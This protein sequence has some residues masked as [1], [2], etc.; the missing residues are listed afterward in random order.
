MTG[1]GKWILALILA[2]M[3]ALTAGLRGANVDF[4]VR[5]TRFWFTDDY[6]AYDP[7]GSE[8]HTAK[9]WA[10]DNSNF[11]L[12]GGTA[13]A[14]DGNDSFEYDVADYS[15][16]SKS[17][18]TATTVT[19]R[20]EA[21]EDDTGSRTTY[22]TST[23]DDDDAH[24]GPADVA[25]IS[26][27]NQG[28]NAWTEYGFYGSQSQKVK[29]AIFWNYSTPAA[30]TALDAV[31]VT[32]SGF[33]ARWSSSANADAYRLDVSTDA[34]F[35]SYVAGYQNRL[36]SGTE[37]TVSLA[38][39]TTYFYRVRA[40][41]GDKTSGSSNTV[42]TV[43]VPAAPVLTASDGGQTGKVVLTWTAVAGADGGYDVFRHTVNDAGGATQ[44]NGSAV[45]TNATEDVSVN[46]GPPLFGVTYYY[47]V[48]A[49]N[50]VS[51][52]GALSAA[53]SGFHGL[54][55][56]PGLTA[57]RGTDPDKVQLAWAVVPVADGYKV[58]RNSMD[59]P[60][61]ATVI[62]TLAGLGSTSFADTTAAADAIYYY[63]VVSTL[64]GET[65]RFSTAAIGQ[66]SL[67]VPGN[68]TATIGV[69]NDRIRVSWAAAPPSTSYQIFRSTTPTP[70]GSPYATSTGTSFD[71]TGV[72][73]GTTYY[74]WVRGTDGSRFSALS[75]ATLGALGAG[76]S[77][78]LGVSAAGSVKLTGS[79]SYA[80]EGTPYLGYKDNTWPSDDDQWRAYFWWTHA[81]LPAGIAIDQAVLASLGLVKRDYEDDDWFSPRGARLG[82][83]RAS[84]DGAG[85]STRYGWMNI[86]GVS[87]RY[88]EVGS[89][90]GNSY[91]R[92]SIVLERSHL[93]AVRDGNFG[94]GFNFTDHSG[95]SGDDST[96]SEVS[97]G[98]ITVSYFTRPTL[99]SPATGTQMS[100]AS[101]FNLAWNPALTTFDRLNY[102]VQVA[103]NGSFSP[104]LVDTL[105]TAT[106]QAVS[107]A[108][109]GTYSWRV[110]IE[111]PAQ[112]ENA[113]AWSD[114]WTVV[115][116]PPPIPAAPSYLTARDGISTAFVR[117]TW[118][119]VALAS[120]YRVFRGTSNDP[121]AASQIGTAAS[122]LYEDTTAAA[123]Q[124][125]YYW[126]KAVNSSG[127]SVAFSPGDSGYRANG[128]AVVAPVEAQGSVWYDHDG[129]WGED[130]APYFGWVD[131]TFPVDDDHYIA[132]F[133]WQKPALP[134]G[135]AI[136]QAVID[137][138]GFSKNNFKD[139]D[140][141]VPHAARIPGTKA[142]FDAAGNA[143]NRWNQFLANIYSL[144]PR[145]VS[146]SSDPG[147]S[148]AEQDITVFRSHIP[149]LR[150]DSRFGLAFDSLDTTGDTSDD[151]TRMLAN[152]GPITATYYG[153][154]AL[155]APADLAGFPS[156]QPV[157]LQWNGS[158][159]FS[160]YLRT[161]LQV[162]TDSGFAQ[163]VLN[164]E[165]VETAA[166]VELVDGGTYYWRVRVED[167]ETAGN[168]SAWSETR[169][170]VLTNPPS[171]PS[172]P[173]NVA[174]SDGLYTG[175]V[176]VSWN[177][178]AYAS[179]Y[180]V[181][182]AEGNNSGA[183]TLLGSTSET[184]F[185]DTSAPV[186]A[187]RHYWVKA[188][189]NVGAS[190]F[191]AVDSGYRGIDFGVTVVC[192]LAEAGAIENDTVY[193]FSVLDDAD[194]GIDDGSI[195]NTW[196]R[197]YLWWN[198]AAIPDGVAIDR[199]TL[200][201]VGYD[202]VNFSA[203]SEKRTRAIRIPVAYGTFAG[204]N[205]AGRYEDL[206]TTGN[207]KEVY[208]N[209]ATSNGASHFNFNVPVFSRDLPFL[210]AGDRFGLAFGAD[211][212]DF[213]V[214]EDT[215][216]FRARAGSLTVTYFHTP[217]LVEPV[218]GVT[219]AGGTPVN[220]AWEE[221]L[222]FGGDTYLRYRIQVATTPDF[223]NPF[224]NLISRETQFGLSGLAD[225]QTY[226]WRIRIE[227]GVN[228]DNASAWS[229]VRHF[230]VPLPAPGAPQAVQAT[231]G[232][233]TDR[234][235]V[236]W[237]PVLKATAYRV[238]RHTVD[239]SGEAV[240]LGE[241]AEAAWTDTGVAAGT[242]YFYWVQA[243][244]A[245]GASALSAAEAGYRGLG[246][247]A[248]LMATDGSNA[249]GITLTWEALAEAT[250]YLLWRGTEDDPL[251]LEAPLATLTGTSFTDTTAADG[252]NYF[253]WIQAENTVATSL[254][255]PA[256]SGYRGLAPPVMV[257]AT[258]GTLSDRIRVTWSA[259]TG[260]TSYQL[261]R[262]TS[263]QL[264]DSVLLAS[265]AGTS[266]DDTIAAANQLYTYWVRS[267]ANAQLSTASVA[268][269]GY[270]AI[271]TPAGVAASDGTLP[272]KV[273]VT[274]QAVAAGTG[275]EIFRTLQNVAP[276]VGESPLA[277]VP[278]SGST[279]YED[280]T[281]EAG[282][283]YYY[284]VRTAHPLGTSAFGA[285][286]SGYAGPTGFS[287][288]DG[289][290]LDKVE[291]R[292]AP[293]FGATGYEIWRG[294]G[295]SVGSATL[296]TTAGSGARTWADTTG[297][298]GEPYNYWF[299]AVTPGGPTAFSELT[300][301]NRGNG[302]T[303]T[304]NL[305]AAGSIE[306]GDETH[307][308]AYVGWVDNT[309][310]A[311]DDNY[312]A[313]FWWESSGV[314][315]GAAIGEARVR[316][317]GYSKNN[318]ADSDWSYPKSR[319]IPVSRTA[320]EALPVSGQ[321]AMLEITPEKETFWGIPTDRGNAFTGG[322]VRLLRED[323]VLLRNGDGFG[324]GWDATDTTGGPSDDSTR[325]II[326]AGPIDVD[327]FGAPKLVAPSAGSALASGSVVELVWAPVFP[328]NKNLQYRVQVAESP[329]FASPL[330]NR[331]Q[332]QSSYSLGS[333]V[334]GVKTYFWRVR[335]EDKSLAGIAAGEVD[336]PDHNASAWSSALSFTISAPAGPPNAPV[337]TDA[338]DGTY[339]TAV[340]VAWAAVPSASSYDIFR[341][342]TA[343]SAEAVL[344][345]NA[346]VDA[347]FF[348]DTSAVPGT[349]Y[350]Y[351][352]KGKNNTGSSGLSN[353]VEGYRF[354]APAVDIFPQ[355]VAS[356]D[357]TSDSV[358]LWTRV[359]DP[360]RLNE[361][362]TV[363]LE[364]ATDA[365]FGNIVHTRTNLRARA[366]HDH[367][368][369]VRVSGL[370]PYTFYYYRFRYDRE[371]PPASFSSR[372]GRTKTAPLPGQ[373]VPVRFAV[374]SCQDII[375]KYYNSLLDLTYR[376]RDTLDFVLY[377][378]DYIY[379]TTGNP[380]FQNVVDQERAVNFQDQ[381]GAINNTEYYAAK[382]LSNYRDLYK[383]YRKDK[384]LQQL[385]ELYPILVT[386]DD[387]EYSDDTH[388]ATS[389]YFDE[390][391]DEYDPVR[392]RNAERAF[393]EYQPVGY[394][395]DDFGVAVTDA[396]LYPDT[397]PLYQNFRYGS[398]AELLITDFR[399]YRPDHLVP[400][401]AFPGEIIMTEAEVKA[402][403]RGVN[404]WTQQQL[405]AQWP[406]LRERFDPYDPDFDADSLFGVAVQAAVAYMY[407]DQ[408]GLSL[409]EAT[410]R[411]KQVVRNG[412]LSANLVNVAAQIAG[413]DIGY[414][415]D[416]MASFPRGI[417][418]MFLAKVPLF[419]PIGSRYAILYDNFNLY[420]W[421][422]YQES[423]GAT[424][425][426]YGDTQMQWIHD[427]LSS[428]DA[429]WKLFVN[430]TSF[431]PMILDI[432]KVREKV[433]IEI[434]SI[435]PESL[436]HLL[437]N[438]IMLNGDAWDGFPNKKKEMLDLFGNYNA[439]LLAGDIHST[440]ITRHLAPNGKLVP[441]FTGTSVS[442]GTVEGLI[443]QV[444]EGYP[445]VGDLLD[446][447]AVTPLLK[448][449]F[450][451]SAV[452]ANTD[453]TILDAALG[454][455]GYN[456]VEV[457][458]GEV[459]VLRHE[460]PF[461]H[462][463]DNFYDPARKDE[464]NEKV[465]I[466]RHVVTC[467]TDA[468]TGR[469][470]GLAMD[471]GTRLGTQSYNVG[472]VIDGAATR[473]V[474]MSQNGHPTPFTLNLTASD[475]DGDP[476][477]WGLAQAP[478]HGVAFMAPTAG[479]ATGVV[480]RPGEDYLGSDAFQVRVRDPNGG[481]AV[482]TV[483][484]TIE[485][486]EEAEAWVYDQLKQLG[487]AP[488][489]DPELWSD[490]GDPDADG[491]PNFLEYA[492][493][494]DPVKSGESAQ[495][496][497]TR[498][499]EEAEEQYFTFQYR[500]RKSAVAGGISYVVQYST[501]L[502]GWV[503]AQALLDQPDPPQDLGGDFELVT[504]RLKDPLEPGKP[505]FLRV[506]VVK[507]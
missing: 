357:P 102:R 58:L 302:G 430:S 66:R 325:V 294:T 342:T 388:G 314:P 142:A 327:Y 404:G 160:P 286:D 277:A 238:Y 61:T 350:H 30:P 347:T 20:L 366:T 449:L 37:L 264:N 291:L 119:P 234:V 10:Y 348:Y 24:Y 190:G 205:E 483:E 114:V 293:V 278:G 447:E 369:K 82:V 52:V 431:T 505:R 170:F 444:A 256:D 259:V 54:G 333:L 104:V 35:G 175:Q 118:E 408:E 86:D 168:E 392:K 269:T 156:G 43:T 331:A 8:E 193:G 284:W 453:S 464:L 198:T 165:L 490:T 41:N 285:G 400:E 158:S 499:E 279:T 71:D 199:A 65:S 115:V 12:T 292:W 150:E 412:R 401:A 92:N 173:G 176:L 69:F 202:P 413:V 228:A 274:W 306:D 68:P 166:E 345:G 128:G 507:P 363:S 358:V 452:F 90:P 13:V 111:D 39:G 134:A 27:R 143:Q 59:N 169:R 87:P 121:A 25:T 475:A 182:R 485:G 11:S 97:A 210:S 433:E 207:E 44:L 309:W 289:L 53:D 423:G 51:G 459:R 492:L 250:G 232:D 482:V 417:S 227:S 45:M 129:D 266:Y 487:V 315:G 438:R 469:V 162:A 428:S 457:D 6:D 435:V 139:N 478:A 211:E 297:G 323:L 215:S 280:A 131:N 354:D 398:Q 185:Q 374:V 296:L 273:A 329:D 497:E 324:L 88:L 260:A 384:A 144:E 364:V 219:V 494:G 456:V 117:V 161:R 206:K 476:L 91:S 346:P 311:S 99:N 222:S 55:A 451:E 300:T 47:W 26:F 46:E 373:D 407:M 62:A 14:A 386:W 344:V 399:T 163:L 288:S 74:Y 246:Q 40:E 320:F 258:D 365:T 263:G 305:A 85:N 148:Y 172:A 307:G 298:A 372:V 467:Q 429:K 283:Q 257:T 29:V 23:F 328:N 126:V 226:Y 233:F 445:S 390:K 159:V 22:G 355:S 34:G 98:A 301:G 488:D 49:R 223:S 271:A 103:N 446:I 489:E 411:A 248:G 501:D 231:D 458:G 262:G 370:Q 80:G 192:P 105:S 217:A 486:V 15:I 462:V 496:A 420:A 481:E 338:S 242:R 252:V 9:V 353:A 178:A 361:D 42:T 171:A 56:P 426:V 454:S 379:E 473:Q 251:G 2:W 387:H 189:N 261:Y 186:N 72:V 197:G 343:N 308:S 418:Y 378:G 335:V 183:A 213:G 157:N 503:D 79:G 422:R 73:A 243:V 318:Y 127:E 376:H 216:I 282:T 212:D 498:I 440:W 194:F 468:A 500:R 17:A 330:V 122:A 272:G 48:R 77:V 287:A 437:D 436:L 5:V 442:S 240:L 7:G 380:E 4:D 214:V 57:S 396:I 3:L 209:H 290:F 359:V 316:T 276:A 362:L 31:N 137:Q 368:V 132:W 1:R 397:R 204:R 179:S 421:H 38:A 109:A 76:S 395:F 93:T 385:H 419:G 96:K 94:L 405:D 403:L 455:N 181:W 448:P 427:T 334:D 83:T 239:A 450:Q 225:N 466:T 416:E 78:D 32:A 146:V 406:R 304:L 461:F 439:V 432:G 484:V 337:V 203:T 149:F 95:S 393:I 107:F 265:L 19:I 303:V 191:S 470:T 89:N 377:M 460:L 391:F 145:Y 434:P 321:Y 465:E 133:W 349:P 382:S 113:S 367:C 409:S 268:E 63:W 477:S 201:Y 479:N 229:P 21:W 495:I 108:D 441:E 221:V 187:V 151:S 138:L 360:D 253:Y 244:N 249:S 188:L 339:Q 254:F 152:A 504:V 224:I 154:P 310:P 106:A 167:K 410:G 184:Y 295:K 230:T 130:G 472:P 371:S 394:G 424:E 64:G 502:L 415:A 81:G 75:E 235:E 60:A 341:A 241:T 340:R 275:Y 317:L 50:T 125:Y 480:Y 136:E 471:E 155:Q 383:I 247:P 319:R 255:S 200:E 177:P 196:Y 124:A 112:P 218:H 332:M 326:A 493:G 84:W 123:G 375:G 164:L 443:A 474:T 414:D 313:W 36:V 322:P 33:K 281:A 236:T 463:T 425:N 140:W 402:A 312:R 67:P 270:V 141:T 506:K 220:L 135:V 237:S 174:A 381:A 116:P 351:W 336:H 389:S 299:R 195:W 153:A 70:P 120:S 110:R 245:A 180:Q 16:R 352:V 356:G 491:I 267:V 28:L 101:T 147:S 208:L 100:A 18:T